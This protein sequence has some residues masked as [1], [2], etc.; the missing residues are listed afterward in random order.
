M[1]SAV[2]IV[3]QQVTSWLQDGIWDAYSLLSIIS[4]LKGNQNIYVTASSDNVQ[5]NGIADWLLEIPAIVPLLIASALLLAFYAWVAAI[6]KE[7]SIGR[8]RG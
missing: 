6:E 5:T 8:S 4:R 3:G 7:I 1:L 2:L